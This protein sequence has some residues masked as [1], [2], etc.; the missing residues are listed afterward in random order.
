MKIFGAMI[1]VL[2]LDLIRVW[3][4]RRKLLL[5]Y[6]GSEGCGLQIEDRFKERLRW[7]I[8][9]SM[10]FLKNLQQPTT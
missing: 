5:V 3:A 1:P 7:G 6:T 10:T 8:N 2:R 9:A 4:N